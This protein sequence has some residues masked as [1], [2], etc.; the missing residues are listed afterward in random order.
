M[1]LLIP[2]EQIISK[3]IVLRNGKVI[4]DTHLAEIYKVE[5]RV[6]KQAVRRNLDLFPDDFM[7][8]LS[9]KEVEIAVSQKMI[10]SKQYLGG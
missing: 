9:D 8:I 3:I 10:T 6:L 2:T 7:F 5:N 1:A 4:L